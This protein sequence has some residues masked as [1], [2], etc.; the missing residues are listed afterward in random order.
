MTTS[1][2]SKFILCDCIIAIVALGTASFVTA[3]DL[4]VRLQP[5]RSQ[6]GKADY[7]NLQVVF[8]EKDAPE[9]RLIVTDAV[10]GAAAGNA[11][12]VILPRG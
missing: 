2:S 9:Q 1:R 7:D 10:P 12:W 8:V 5:S 6:T 11:I 3:S 4:E